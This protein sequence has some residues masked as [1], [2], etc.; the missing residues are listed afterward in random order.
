MALVLS[1]MASAEPTER[2]EL[3][4]MSADDAITLRAKVI[5]ARAGSSA[6]AAPDGK[7]IIVQDSV[8]RIE[9]LRQL[10]TWLDLP[11]SKTR[12]LH[13]RPVLHRQPSE[14][15][16]LTHRVFGD[17]I[18]REVGLAAD[19]RSGKLIVLAKPSEYRTID[20]LL[21]RLDIPPRDDRRIFV[22]P[23]RTSIPLPGR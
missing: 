23:G 6:T 3:K 20:R 9:R 21:R 4:E 5:G 17:Y 1:M 8:G 13:V 19:D 22:L 14:L 11:G 15:V 10:I 7:S 16:S 2:I 18:G 12:R